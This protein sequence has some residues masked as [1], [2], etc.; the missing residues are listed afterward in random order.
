MTN[1]DELF[2]E[3]VDLGQYPK[4]K[5]DT[6]TVL[7]KMGHFLDGEV[8]RLHTWYKPDGYSNQDI[9]QLIDTDC[10]AAKE[11]DVLR[12]ASAGAAPMLKHQRALENAEHAERDYN[13]GNSEVS[14]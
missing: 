6:V 9:N 4:E 11:I 12:R 3:L 5:I 2:Q 7:E 13:R 14:H 8:Q 10:R 1:V